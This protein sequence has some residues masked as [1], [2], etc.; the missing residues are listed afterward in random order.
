MALDRFILRIIRNLIYRHGYALTKLLLIGSDNNTQALIDLFTHNTS[1]GYQVIKAIPDFNNHKVINPKEIE[2]IIVVDS[3]LTAEQR[4]SI[5]EFCTEN[6]LNFK[7][8]ADV[9]N[10]QIHNIVIHTYA[11]L[12]ILEIKPTPLEG[13]GRVVKRFVDIVL[14]IIFII[15]LSPLM[16]F[17]AAVIKFKYGSPIIVSLPRIG[18]R[19][20]PFILHKFRSM[21][22][23]AE[24]M[25][26]SLMKLNERNDGPLFKLT[27]DPR[28]LP[29]GKFIRSWS[30]DELPQFFNVLLGQMSLVGPRPHEPQ[31]VAKYQT[32]HKK[33]LSIKPGITGL[34]QIS[35][36]SSLSFIDEV[37]LDSFYIENWSLFYDLF[38]LLKTIVVIFQRKYAA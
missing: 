22:V 28:I 25:K 16:L 33:V 34:A 13:W 1:Y 27:H 17:I 5:W 38:I 26:E 4:L 37:R 19:G 31:E 24:K 18:E 8:V 9:F 15:I 2:E 36:R 23:G 35:G 30:L 6:H 3:N 12:P 32:N 29:F 10:A 7:Y 11:G 14:S 20:K 21:V